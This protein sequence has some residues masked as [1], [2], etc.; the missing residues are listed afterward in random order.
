MHEINV[1]TH[2]TTFILLTSEGYSIN[3]IS[4]LLASPLFS[5]KIIG[6]LQEEENIIYLTIFPKDEQKRTYGKSKEEFIKKISNICDYISVVYDSE[7]VEYMKIISQSVYNLE[8]EFRFLI[9]YVFLK[10]YGKDWYKKFF[11]D[12]SKEY[13][14][15]KDRSEVISYIDNPLDNRN[16][17]D[18]KNFVEEDI[19]IS[20]NTMVEKLNS[21]EEILNTISSKNENSDSL[22]IN[23]LNLLEEIKDLSEFKTSKVSGLDIYNHITPEISKEWQTLYTS[24]RNLWAHNYCLMTQAE[25]GEYQALSEGVLTKIR[26]EITLLS[27]LKE[28]NSLH[29]PSNQNTTISIS[30]NQITKT[31]TSLCKLTLNVDT[32]KT[33][34]ILEVS[35]ATYK[36]LINILSI[37]SIETDCPETKNYLNLIKFNP[38]LQE[39]LKAIADEILNSPKLK[40]TLKLDFPKIEQLFKD[41]DSTYLFNELDLSS[42]TKKADLNKYLKKIHNGSNV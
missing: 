20:K 13:D 22:Y 28:E 32:E 19:S 3:S 24:Y 4:D 33:R 11:K 10:K 1:K 16:F 18:L 27:L 6:E 15:S 21:V 31:G 23:V 39:R 36:D 34:Y 29:Y 40:Q 8:R 7:T 42:A 30:M 12:S 35:E 41:S 14:R 25:L 5:S 17:I 26:T 38:F 37:L 9:E 2:H